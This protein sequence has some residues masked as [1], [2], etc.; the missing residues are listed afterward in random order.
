MRSSVGRE[1]VWIRTQKNVEIHIGNIFQFDSNISDG[2][3]P[4]TQVRTVFL[5]STG[6]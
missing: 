5:G 3:K 1:A 2:L 4:S 6:K